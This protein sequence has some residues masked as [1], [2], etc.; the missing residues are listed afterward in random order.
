MKINFEPLV[1]VE[2]AIIETGGE[3]IMDQT[4]E[5]ETE[6]ELPNPDLAKLNSII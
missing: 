1:Q 6:G 2:V 3:I 4:T 5:T